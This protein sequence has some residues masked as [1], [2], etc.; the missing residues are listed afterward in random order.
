MVGKMSQCC[1]TST[2][3]ASHLQETNQQQRLSKS[4]TQFREYRPQHN[5]CFVLLNTVIFIPACRS[6]C[7]QLPMV[8]IRHQDSAVRA[9]LLGA[10]QK[11]NNLILLSKC[12]GESRFVMNEHSLQLLKTKQPFGGNLWQFLAS[13]TGRHVQFSDKR[14]KLPQADNDQQRFNK[15]L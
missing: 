3:G 15:S 1:F 2:G 12:F 7:F 5:F 4:S 10:L 11:T 14:Q 8:S 9:H 13:M 6:M